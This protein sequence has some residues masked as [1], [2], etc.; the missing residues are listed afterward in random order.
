MAIVNTYFN[1]EGI[2]TMKIRKVFAEGKKYMTKTG[3][4]DVPFE[5]YELRSANSNSPIV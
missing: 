2:R 4:A 1:M 5:N 3:V